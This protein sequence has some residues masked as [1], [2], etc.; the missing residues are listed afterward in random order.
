[1]LDYKGQ[2]LELEYLELLKVLLTVVFMFLMT[3]EDS[4]VAQNQIKEKKSPM[5]LVPIYKDL[6]VYTYKIIYLKWKTATVF[7]KNN[8]VK[9]GHN[10][11]NVSKTTILNLK[12]QSNLKMEKKLTNHLKNFT[13]EYTKKLKK[14]HPVPLENKESILNINLKNLDKI[15]LSTLEEMVKHI[16]D[17]EDLLTKKEKTE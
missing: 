15:I 11:Y 4:Q 7:H 9:D 10:G 16:Q 17:K 5:T 3:P 13:M 12:S 6:L 2:Q 14:I 1:M 8:S